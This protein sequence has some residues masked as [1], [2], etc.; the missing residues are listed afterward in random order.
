VLLVAV[1]DGAAAPLRPG[2]AG[3]SG[4]HG[5]RLVAA[6]SDDWGSDGHDEGKRVWFALRRTG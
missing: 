6:L 5:L 2:G 4:G 3:G 1:L